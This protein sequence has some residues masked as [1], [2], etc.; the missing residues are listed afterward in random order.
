MCMCY[1]STTKLKPFQEK[2]SSKHTNVLLL[3]PLK[4]NVY[5]QFYLSSSR[6]YSSQGHTEYHNIQEK[7]C[8]IPE[9]LNMSLDSKQSVCVNRKRKLNYEKKKEKETS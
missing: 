3:A 9:K 6:P 8:P 1:L 5:K 7:A 2:S 4:S